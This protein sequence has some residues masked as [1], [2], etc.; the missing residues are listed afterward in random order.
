[1]KSKI[2]VALL[3]TAGLMLCAGTGGQAAYPD[4]GTAGV[5]LILGDTTGASGKLWLSENRALDAGFGFSGD[6]AAHAGHLWH[7]WN[8]LPQP[9]SGR[10]GAYASLGGRIEL[11]RGDDEF[12]I[13]TMGGADYLM[14][15]YPWEFFAEIGPV[16]RMIPDTGVSFAGGLGARYLFGQ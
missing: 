10:L 13:R 1:M 6:F 7:A 3:M 5:G 9:P 4:R 2:A 15:N 14:E 11:K 16:I 12:G 8:A